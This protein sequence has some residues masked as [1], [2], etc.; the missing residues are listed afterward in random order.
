ML[1]T[2]A[3]LKSNITDKVLSEEMDRGEGFSPFVFNG[4]LLLNRRCFL[5]DTHQKG[6]PSDKLRK[7]FPFKQK[8]FL[9]SIN[10]MFWQTRKAHAAW[11]LLCLLDCRRKW[12]LCLF[13]SR[14]N[15]VNKERRMDGS[16]MPCLVHPM[17]TVADGHLVR[18]LMA[19]G[20]AQIWVYMVCIPPTIWYA[21]NWIHAPDPHT[22]SSSSPTRFSYLQV[23]STTTPLFSAEMKIGQQTTRGNQKWGLSWNSRKHA[24]FHFC[25]YWEASK[26]IHLVH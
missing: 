14:C 9:R 23:F 6:R 5:N 18:K 4:W 8:H 22:S 20:Y 21:Q 12:I 3:N 13:V 15:Q 1:N 11:D 10:G 25:Y 19:A 16:A 2:H 24:V 17:K 7:S 26:N